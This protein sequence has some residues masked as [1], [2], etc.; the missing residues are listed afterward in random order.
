MQW[1]QGCTSV[2]IY[3]M[4]IQ[5]LIVPPAFS[6]NTKFLLLSHSSA[7]IMK[8]KKISVST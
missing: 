8:L 2:W 5:D 6:Y 3:H 1:L 7:V 4:M